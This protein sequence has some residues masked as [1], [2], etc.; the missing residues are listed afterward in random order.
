MKTF[1]RQ[2]LELK[3]TVFR[4]AIH[5][6]E[7]GNSCTA[8]M[9]LCRMIYVTIRPQ[10][11]SDDWR[12]RLGFLHRTCCLVAIV[13]PSVEG[14]LQIV[15]YA[16]WH[17]IRSGNDNSSSWMS[18]FVRHLLLIQTQL[19]WIST[20]IKVI[21]APLKIRLKLRNPTSISQVAQVSTDTAV[22]SLSDHICKLIIYIPQSIPP[23]DL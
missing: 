8:A 15:Q 5:Y 22:V 9:R 11:S 6:W 17:V 23:S 3:K 16:F 4:S 13:V 7:R 2:I 12:Y 10:L 14:Y 20:R 1:L 19:L 18:C 21:D